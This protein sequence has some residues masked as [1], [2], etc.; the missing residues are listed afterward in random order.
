MLSHK[1]PRN[2]GST[3]SAS[4]LLRL[5]LDSTRD[6]LTIVL[7]QFPGIWV[8]VAMPP[9]RELFTLSFAIENSIIRNPKFQSLVAF[10]AAASS[11]P[12]AGTAHG[13]PRSPR[14]DRCTVAVETLTND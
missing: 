4:S 2:A 6:T 5:L 8:S 3:S 13:I 12:G 1:A 11:A 10:S 14:K 7:A 9:A